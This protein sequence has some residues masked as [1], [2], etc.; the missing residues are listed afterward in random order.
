MSP[1]C[2]GHQGMRV[3]LSYL[4]FLSPPS[5][6]VRLQQYLLGISGCNFFVRYFHK[7]VFL[8]IKPLGLIIAS[9]S[10]MPGSRI[11]STLCC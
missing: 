11:F 5:L 2:D 4:L 7:V 9:C 8:L 3:K 1:S 10:T 6:F